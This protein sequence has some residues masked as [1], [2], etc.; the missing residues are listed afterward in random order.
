MNLGNNQ[1]IGY[2]KCVVDAGGARGRSYDIVVGMTR[3]MR[4]RCRATKVVQRCQNSLVLESLVWPTL[5]IVDD[6]S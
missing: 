4:G 6:L 2:D 3:G 5:V 1:K